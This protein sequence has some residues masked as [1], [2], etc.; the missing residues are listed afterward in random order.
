MKI[1]RLP[2]AGLLVLCL[3][4][5]AESY[6]WTNPSGGSWSVPG[7]W[8]PNGVPGSGDEVVID[9][10]GSYT[11]TIPDNVSVVACGSES[12]RSPDPA[13][14]DSPLSAMEPLG[15]LLLP[16]LLDA[17]FV[18]LRLLPGGTSAVSAD[19]GLPRNDAELRPGRFVVVGSEPVLTVERRAGGVFYAVH[20]RAGRRYRVERAPVLGAG[21]WTPL[22]ETAADAETTEVPLP[23]SEAVEFLRAVPVE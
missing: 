3:S 21:V 9:W 13:R 19:D 6:V 2:F 20:G 7:N 17:R 14:P 12:W 4:L 8:L 23:M 5:A 16:T 10:P 15:E 22:M 18:V 11:V 1:T